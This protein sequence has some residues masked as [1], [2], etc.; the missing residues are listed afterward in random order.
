MPTQVTGIDTGDSAIDRAGSLR[1]T[2]KSVLNI[3]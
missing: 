1:H 2:A 3:H